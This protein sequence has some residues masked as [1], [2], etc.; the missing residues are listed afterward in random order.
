M[1]TFISD[2]FSFHQRVIMSMVFTYLFSIVYPKQNSYAMRPK[3]TIPTVGSI[4]HSLLVFATSC[5]SSVHTFLISKQVLIRNIKC[6]L[7]D[8][9]YEA[10]AWECLWCILYQLRSFDC[11]CWLNCEYETILFC[12]DLYESRFFPWSLLPSHFWMLSFKNSNLISS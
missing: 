12:G 5:P 7:R 1:I 9:E 10:C 6:C 2:F 11:T 4:T 3:H 8:G